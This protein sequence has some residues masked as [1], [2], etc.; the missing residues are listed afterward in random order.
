M[1]GTECSALNREGLPVDDRLLGFAGSM[2]VYRRRDRRIQAQKVWNATGMVAMP[3]SEEYM[4]EADV[5]IRKGRRYQV[6]PLWDP[7]A[8]VDKKTFGASTYD[9][10]IGTLEGELGKLC[11]RRSCGSVI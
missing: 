1:N 2:L 5:K 11:Q 6:G 3:V 9:I 10:S 7:L 4:G 8:S